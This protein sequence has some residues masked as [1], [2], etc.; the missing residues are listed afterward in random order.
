MNRKLISEALSNVED[1]F[2]VETML[3]GAVKR[4]RA[5]ERTIH[6][7]RTT[8][9]ENHIRTRRLIRLALAACL[10]FALAVTAYAFNFLG[11]RE[12]LNHRGDELPSEAYEY[13]QTHDMSIDSTVWRCDVTESLTDAQ[14]IY[15]TVTVTTPGK[16]ILAPAD[17]SAES[18][19]SVIGLDGTQTLGDYAAAQEKE[20]LFLSMDIEDRDALGITHTAQSFESV[21]PQEMTILLHANK[22]ESTPIRD[23]VCVVTGVEEIAVRSHHMG[24]TLVE[25]PTTG[26]GAYVPDDPNGIPGVIIGEATIN[27]TPLGLSIRFMETFVDET[28]LGQI[29]KVVFEGLEYREGGLVLDDDGNWYFTVS[30]CTGDIGDTLTAR[31]YDW[32]DQV[33][34]TVIFKQN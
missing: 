29:K 27:E 28:A 32:D 7:N 33:V 10:I 23:V 6:M 20:L 24:I 15:I 9:R 34:G 2:I 31:F 1:S 11:I 8:S 30:R 19:T 5:P 26:S 25:A 16:Y 21:S 22:T 4:D 17:A 14:N 18:L 3:P 12:M 13:I